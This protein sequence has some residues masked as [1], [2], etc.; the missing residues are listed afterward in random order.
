MAL[1]IAFHDAAHKRSF[2]DFFSVTICLH[3]YEGG[4]NKRISCQVL[5]FLECSNTTLKYLV[6]FKLIVMPKTWVTSTIYLEIFLDSARLYASLRPKK[7]VTHCNIWST[8]LLF[9]LRELCN[10]IWHNQVLTVT[11]KH[12]REL[13]K[14]IKHLQE[15]SS[16]IKN[17]PA[18][19]R[20]I[21]N[22]QEL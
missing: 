9:Y 17:Y 19:S 8:F 12:Y 4:V 13:S 15:L 22:Y 16:T 20:T 1:K 2:G 7:V 11:I 18:L 21:G 10:F 3:F 5:T 14:T 6:L